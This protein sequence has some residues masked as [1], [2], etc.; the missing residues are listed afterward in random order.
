MKNIFTSNIELK[1]IPEK[2]TVT[3]LKVKKPNEEIKAA[4]LAYYA[5]AEQAYLLNRLA[6]DLWERVFTP[7]I[8]EDI[9]LTE[10]EDSSFI[11]LIINI[12]NAEKKS[13]Y[14]I[15]FDNLETVLQ[16]LQK[17]FSYNLND[18]LTALEYIGNDIRDNLSESIIKNCLRDTIPSSAEELQDYKVVIQATKKLEQAL[19]G[20]K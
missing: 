4:I 14:K 18:N 5:N 3:T 1:Q 20:K 17:H 8:N 7:I 13:D 9:I 15:V 2:P 11:Y 10:K 19:L 6:K 12:K 16:F